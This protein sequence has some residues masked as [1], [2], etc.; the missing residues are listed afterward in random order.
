[1][2]DKKRKG[3]SIVGL[4]DMFPDDAAAERW[5]YKIHWSDGVVLRVAAKTIACP[6][7]I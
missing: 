5:F 1:M 6:C 4:I 3:V 2:S 7:M